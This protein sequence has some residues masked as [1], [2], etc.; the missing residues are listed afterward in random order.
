[1]VIHELK[2]LFNEN[3]IVKFELYGLEYTIERLVDTVIIYPSLYNQRKTSYNS[4]EEL[5]SNHLIYNE[6]ILDNQNQISKIY[7]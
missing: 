6:T 3:E 1:M 5:L 7:I 4:I 2:T